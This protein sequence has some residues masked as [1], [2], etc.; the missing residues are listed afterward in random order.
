MISK[1]SF[2]LSHTY[3]YLLW[4]LTVPRR[5]DTCFLKWYSESKLSRQMLLPFLKLTKTEYL[6]GNTTSNDCE[7]LFSKYKTCL[8]VTYHK[9]VLHGVR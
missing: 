9:P 4:Q 7:E 6:R 1:S 8:N 2:H 5:Y 3:I